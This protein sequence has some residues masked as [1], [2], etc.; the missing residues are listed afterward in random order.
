MSAQQQV[1]QQTQQLIE[2]LLADLQRTRC[3]LPAEQLRPLAERAAEL[4][5][6]LEEAGLRAFVA[7]L[8]GGTTPVPAT[9]TLLDLSADEPGR[10]ASYLRWRAEAGRRVE[11]VWRWGQ[12]RR[13][14]AGASTWWAADSALPLPVTSVRALAEVTEPPVNLAPLVESWGLGS[15]LE[16]PQEEYN[17]RALLLGKGLPVAAGDCPALNDLLSALVARARR[18]GL[19]PTTHRVRVVWRPNTPSMVIPV[20]LPGLSVLSLPTGTTPV[21]VQYLQHEIAHLTEQAARPATTPLNRRWAFD[22]LRSEGWALL[23]EHLVASPQ[24]LVELGFTEEYA[25]AVTAFLAEEECF[26]RG[27]MAADLA[28]DAAWPHCR[29]EAELLAAAESIIARTGLLWAPEVLVMRQT[30]MLNWRAY[31]AGYAWRDAALAVLRL[32]F[33]SDWTQDEAAWAV[34]GR[35]L[36]ST[37]SATDFLAAVG[38]E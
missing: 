23:C 6:P 14:T 24:A 20:R 10:Q 37:G 36:R 33:G 26:S 11:D 3:G 28:L 15:G 12:A 7:E 4:A 38:A 1:Q 35:A 22:P 9:E 34:L 8:L 25:A 5:L 13:L 31:L 30:G 29:D 16:R 27:L 18:H 32:R 17:W 21:T 19:L 2:E